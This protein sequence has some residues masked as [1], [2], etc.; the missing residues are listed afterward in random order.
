M[1]RTPVGVGDE[2][3]LTDAIDMLIEKETV[4]AFHMTGRS[5]DCGDKIGYMEAFVEYS[6]RHDKLGKEFKAFLKDLAKTL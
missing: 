3:Q 5:F 6:L 4:E 2:I 1:E